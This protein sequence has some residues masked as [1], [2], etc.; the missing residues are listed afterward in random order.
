MR[1]SPSLDLGMTG[2]DEIFMDDK[3]LKENRL[4]KILQIPLDRIDEFPDHPFQVRLDEDM[5]QL[6][7]SIKERGVITPV[8]LRKKEDGRYET[9]SGHRRIK[10]CELAGLDTVPAE[11]KQL[12][13]DEAIILMVDSNLQR[14]TILPSEKAKSYQMRMEAVKR[15]PGR[16]AKTNSCPVGADLI[17]TRSDEQL[18]KNSPDSARQIHRYIRLN[19]LIPSVLAMVDEGKIA[20]RPAVELSYLSSEEQE[21]LFAA[22]E[23]ADATPSHAQAIKMKEFSKN[24]KL[25]PEVIES[26]MSEDKPNQ[27]EKIKLSYTQ[28][29]KYIPAS[30]PYEK[31]ADYIYKALEYYQRHRE[32][33]ER[34]DR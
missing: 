31:T 16:P 12:T 6:V 33:M 18:A 21:Q 13:R 10:A 9:V 24:G 34:N 20:M 32:R 2:F 25:T 1:R 4:P 27:K 26:I 7:E 29:R 15:M 8:T 23:Y 22:M 5:E 19:E 11:I 30:V 17:G 14:T 28:A 3:E